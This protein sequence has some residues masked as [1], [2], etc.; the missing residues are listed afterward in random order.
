L[1]S[2]WGK[3]HGGGAYQN[4]VVL[5]SSLHCIQRAALYAIRG[6]HVVQDLAHKAVEWSAT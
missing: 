3:R 2:T 6:S 4:E 1:P 5:C